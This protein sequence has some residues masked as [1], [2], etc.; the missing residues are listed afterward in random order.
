M[1]FTEMYLASGVILSLR[2]ES[3]LIFAEVSKSIEW[4]REFWHSV[5]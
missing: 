2:I 4:N 1:G 5:G 3:S